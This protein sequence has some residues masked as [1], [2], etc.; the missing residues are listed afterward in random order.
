MTQCGCF[1]GGSLQVQN[2][3]LLS[4]GLSAE[5]VE[6]SGAGPGLWGDLDGKGQAGWVDRGAR[7]ALAGMVSC[8]PAQAEHLLM[9]AVKTEG[10]AKAAGTE[11]VA[12][13]DVGQ[14]VRCQS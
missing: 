9:A 5:T 12:A 13:W 6:G 10:R 3:H 4:L 8:P 11:R 14:C 7:S 2:H 1:I